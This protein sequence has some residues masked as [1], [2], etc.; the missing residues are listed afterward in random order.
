MDKDKQRNI[1]DFIIDTHVYTCQTS[2]IETILSLNVV[3]LPNWENVL[4]LY[5]YEPIQLE[6]EYPDAHFQT[7]ETPVELQNRYEKFDSD[8]AAKQN[9]WDILSKMLSEDNTGLD[10]P[11]IEAKLAK[12]EKQMD[13]ISDALDMIADNLSK[14]VPERMKDIMEWWAIDEWLAE[15]LEELDEP[16]LIFEGNYWWGRTTSGQAIKMD[17]V[18]ETIYNNWLT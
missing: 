7:F 9:E 10:T 5:D 1:E 18:F 14:W 11:D 13:D 17:S 16:V 6:F 12:V 2:L 4:N 3:N 8:M 15:K